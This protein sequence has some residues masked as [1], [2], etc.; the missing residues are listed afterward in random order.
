LE[1][2]HPESDEQEMARYV[3]FLGVLFVINPL[4]IV[5]TFCSLRVTAEDIVDSNTE[6]RVQYCRS[7]V[8]STESKC[9]HIFVR[10][11]VRLSACF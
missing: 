6:T 4:T 11:I 8:Q 7:L 5:C 1:T 10:R 2:G 3:E 9:C